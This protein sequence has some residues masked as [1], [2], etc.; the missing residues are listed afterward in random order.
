MYLPLLSTYIHKYAIQL[1]ILNNII[2]YNIIS[3]IVYCVYISC[4]CM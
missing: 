2:S 3:Y 4:I 1:K